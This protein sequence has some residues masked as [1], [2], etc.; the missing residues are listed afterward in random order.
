M[1]SP[2]STKGL[3]CVLPP[4]GS[5]DTEVNEAHGPGCAKS[6]RILNYELTIEL[7]SWAREALWNV[8]GS[9]NPPPNIA[10][11][12]RQAQQWA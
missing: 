10:L 4:V 3:P 11:C 12:V 8:L 9:L 7:E 6:W 5:G 1:Y 2:L